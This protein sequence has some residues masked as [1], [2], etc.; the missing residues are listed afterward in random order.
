MKATMDRTKSKTTNKDTIKEAKSAMS[1]VEQALA[2]LKD[3]YAKSAE[4]TAF[5]Q[6]NLKAPEDDAPESFDSPY[7]GNQAA[8]GSIIDFLEV[9]LSDFTRL[10][11]ETEASEAQEEE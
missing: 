3:F 2:V 11:S 1:A 7:K 8:G 5:V 10:D 6:A 9:I 4:A